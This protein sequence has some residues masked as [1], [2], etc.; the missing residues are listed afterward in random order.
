M[1]PG[2]VESFLVELTGTRR[3]FRK[4]TLLCY[5]LGQV[6][7]FLNVCIFNNNCVLVVLTSNTEFY[8]SNFLS[9]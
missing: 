4:K 6:E 7:K 1:Q 3:V 5:H 9:K 2:Y 8:V